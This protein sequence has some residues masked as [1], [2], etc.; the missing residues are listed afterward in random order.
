VGFYIWETMSV[1]FP[2]NEML[3]SKKIGFLV[4]K[5]SA[6][7]KWIDGKVIFTKKFC[8]GTK[9]KPVKF[10]FDLIFFEPP[11]SNSGIDS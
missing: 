1:L 2:R 8:F 3:L 9:L 7:R 4:K 6:F 5:S 10:I 11:S